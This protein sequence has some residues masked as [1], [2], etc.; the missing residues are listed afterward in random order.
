MTKKS[1]GQDELNLA[2]IVIG[3]QLI[4][5]IKTTESRQ[6]VKRN[7]FRPSRESLR[8]REM[9]AIE[10]TE[11]KGPREA[12]TEVVAWI[13][14]DD[15][16]PMAVGVG[17]YGPFVPGGYE[18][19]ER[20]TGYRE[21]WNHS[22]I[23]P[24]LDLNIFNL[25]REMFLR[26]GPVPKIRIDTD[27]AVAALAEYY[28]RARPIYPDPPGLSG[29]DRLAFGLFTSGVGGEIVENHQIL[30]GEH[31]AEMG[32]LPIYPHPD[33][34][35][36]DDKPFRP[37]RHDIGWC[38]EAYSNILA[39]EERTGLDLDELQSQPDHPVWDL[40]AHYIAQFCFSVLV[41][42]TP[43]L[44][45][46]GG[47]IVLETPR[48]LDKVRREFAGFIHKNAETAPTYGRLMPYHH[49]EN[50]D[51]FIQS[52]QSYAQ[53]GIGALILACRAIRDADKLGKAER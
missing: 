37:T 9:K 21:R 27:V 20:Q 7:G 53:S 18:I 10:I 45:V 52:T 5:A 6:N 31:H 40:E 22:E 26:H 17:C 43:K 13:C 50:V 25:L 23:T 11:D 33:D 3:R 2:G 36:P 38:L 8:E 28:L 51:R 4:I 48:L 41:T 49:A 16:S 15:R 47:Q 24:M 32:R 29:H 19:R 42:A 46:L 34:T 44:I 1:E 12:L 14:K 39:L 35:G 30:R